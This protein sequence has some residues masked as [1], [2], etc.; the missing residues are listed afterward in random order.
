MKTNERITQLSKRV[1]DLQ[2]AFTRFSKLQDE[3][4]ESEKSDKTDKEILAEIR[5]SAWYNKQYIQTLDLE[6]EPLT[7]TVTI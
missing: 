4:L 5:M 7:F 6:K 2:D 3:I 1:S